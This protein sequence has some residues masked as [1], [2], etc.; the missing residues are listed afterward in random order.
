MVNAG[1][2]IVNDVLKHNGEIEIRLGQKRRVPRNILTNFPEDSIFSGLGGT[3]TNELGSVE[4]DGSYSII[5]FTLTSDSD[6]DNDMGPTAI[7]GRRV[8]NREGRKPIC[9]AEIVSEDRK[10]TCGSEE[11]ERQWVCDFEVL[12][13]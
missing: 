4:P 13:R 1:E 6:L 10:C 2:D 3:G 12:L 8:R 5:L 11:I 7:D 9:V